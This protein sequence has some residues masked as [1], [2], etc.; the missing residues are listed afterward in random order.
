MTDIPPDSDPNAS[1]LPKQG[2]PLSDVDEA[3]RDA[4]GKASEVGRQLAFAGIASIWI[5]NGEKSEAL[6][7]ALLAGLTLLSAA[8]LADFL[9]Y[10]YCAAVWRKFY[11]ENYRVHGSDSAL[12]DVPDALSARTYHFYRAKIL[13]LLAGYVCLLVGALIRLDL[14]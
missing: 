9:Q 10:V 4:S 5:L 7:G 2:K 1:L 8:L 11:N 6:S 13:L 12:I 14:M 3:R